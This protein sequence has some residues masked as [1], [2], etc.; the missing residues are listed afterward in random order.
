MQGLDPDW[1]I[2]H[3]GW[4]LGLGLRNIF[5]DA[6]ILGYAEWWF[7]MGMADFRFDPRNP[8]VQFPKARQLQMVARNNRFACELLTADR[9]VAPTAWQRQ[10]LPPLLRNTCSVIHEGID[11]T[12]F[13]PE[14]RSSPQALPA[15][16]ASL[17]GPES[18]LI[19]YAT[20]GM[21][22]YRG[23]PEA[24]RAL[25]QVLRRQ[26]QVHA[27]IAGRDRV[28]Y[29]PGQ[30]NRL[31]GEEARTLFAKNGVADRV[32]FL[33]FLSL[34]TYR[35][36]LLR[37]TLHLYFSR[38]FVLSWSLLEAMA[39]GCSIVASDVE[40]VREV[41]RDR[42][43]GRLV[44]H[45]APDLATQIEQALN[46]PSSEQWRQAARRRICRHFGREQSLQAYGQLFWPEVA[47]SP[48]LS[49]HVA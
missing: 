43:H 18:P 36:L 26:P 42:V 4:G 45:T 33:G 49:S 19:T 13:S 34:E 41:I 31:Y 14:Q 8:D 12:F 30:K 1:I 28:V 47:A 20:R 23:F 9:I 35:Q 40:P 32:H 37:S 27:A 5:P 17:P 29:A 39:C 10:Q 25:A 15:E 16:L 24:C 2:L 6:R 22:P 3:T 7:E 44:D 38:P 11:T 46:E 48:L 21:D